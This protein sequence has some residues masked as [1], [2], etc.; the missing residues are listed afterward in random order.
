MRSVLEDVPLEKLRF[1]VR[2]RLELGILFL[3]AAMKLIP[4]PS[5]F[6]QEFAIQLYGGVKGGHAKDEADQ[7]HGELM[8]RLTEFKAGRGS[9][10]WPPKADGD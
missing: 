7:R 10:E 2:I 6:W 4:L 3:S 9:G 8:A 5:P 1:T